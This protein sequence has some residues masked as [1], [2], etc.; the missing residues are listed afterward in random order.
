MSEIEE[1]KRLFTLQ[2]VLHKDEGGVFYT[3]PIRSFW[4]KAVFFIFSQFCR[5]IVEI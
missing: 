4:A 5:D 1:C 2:K 3:L